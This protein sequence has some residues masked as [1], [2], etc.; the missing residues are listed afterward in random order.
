MDN[1]SVVKGIV[2]EVLAGGLYRV[3]FEDKERLCYLAGKMKQNHIRVLVGDEVEVILDP[4][5]GTATNR[6]VK[7]VDKVK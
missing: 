4:Y 5:G 2:S 7:R 3:N 1:K 6:I